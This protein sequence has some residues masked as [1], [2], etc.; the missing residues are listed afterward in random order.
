MRTWRFLAARTCPGLQDRLQR[1]S[2]GHQPEGDC[3]SDRPRVNRS[4]L[5]SSASNCST[6]REGV[7]RRELGTRPSP[8]RSRI[9][10][11][12]QQASGWSGTLRT[13][14]KAMNWDI[15]R[16]LASNAGARLDG[17]TC[18]CAASRSRRSASRRAGVARGRPARAPGPTRSS[19]GSLPGPAGRQECLQTAGNAM[20]QRLS[21]R[22]IARLAADIDLLDE[23]LLEIVAGDAALAH[24]PTFISGNPR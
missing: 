7:L 12:R 19:C 24:S 5:S 21:R 1:H 15:D 8:E 3:G 17:R 10:T 20:L 2:Q 6:A 9:R 23:R 14:A 22:H 18:S 4:S 11:S 13:S 16:A